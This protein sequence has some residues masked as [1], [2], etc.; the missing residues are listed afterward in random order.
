MARKEAFQAAVIAII[1]KASRPFGAP[2]ITP[3]LGQTFLNIV[4]AVGERVVAVV[5]AVAARQQ[6]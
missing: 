2:I 5:G 3:E 4:P 6:K 1:G